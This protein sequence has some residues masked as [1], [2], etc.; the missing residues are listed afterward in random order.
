[1]CSENG[2]TFGSVIVGVGTKTARMVLLNTSQQDLRKGW[3]GVTQH[4]WKYVVS[5][6]H[7]EGGTVGTFNSLP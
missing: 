1:M 7:C 3:S 2:F 4:S 6:L 5:G